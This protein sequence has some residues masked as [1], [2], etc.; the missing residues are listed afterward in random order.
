[1]AALGIVEV[2]STL[3]PNIMAVQLYLLASLMVF[4][5]AIGPLLKDPSNPKYRLS[6]W[7]FLGLAMALSPITLP[8]M[9]KKRVS[10]QRSSASL[11]AL[12]L[13]RV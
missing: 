2:Q 7:A 5:L 8:G 12:S 6:S 4:L 10:K 1:M 11:G 3:L 13:F 9:L